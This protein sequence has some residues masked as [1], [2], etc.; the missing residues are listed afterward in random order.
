MTEQAVSQLRESLSSI[1]QAAIC[2]IP[3][4]SADSEL[5]DASLRPSG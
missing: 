1:A 4:M 2:V 5:A 3:G